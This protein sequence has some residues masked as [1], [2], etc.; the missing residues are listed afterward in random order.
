VI[1]GFKIGLRRMN[2]LNAI[3]TWMRTT[4]HWHSFV[5]SPDALGEELGFIDLIHEG[6]AIIEVGVIKID[7][8]KICTNSLISK[9]C[10]HLHE[11]SHIFNAADPEFFT[12]IDMALTQW[13]AHRDTQYPVRPSSKQ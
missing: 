9:P 2:L 10:G 4:K 5:I 8:V 7:H 12:K 1:Y 3:D 13:K 11:T 6:S